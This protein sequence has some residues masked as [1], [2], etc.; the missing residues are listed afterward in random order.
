VVV[1]VFKDRIVPTFVSEHIFL[2]QCHDKTISGGK[3]IINYIINNEMRWKQME[4]NFK[5]VFPRNEVVCFGINR[6]MIATV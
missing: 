2:Q 4:A 1:D 5:L 3:V 6:V